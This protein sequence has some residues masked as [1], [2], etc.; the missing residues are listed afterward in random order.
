MGGISEEVKGEGW[1]VGGVLEESRSKGQITQEEEEF[2][3]A[4]SEGT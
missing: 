4:L 3:K 1:N 2:G